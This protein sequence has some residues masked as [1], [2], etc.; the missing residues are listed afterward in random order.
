MEQTWT[1]SGSYADWTMTITAVTPEHLDHLDLK[2]FPDRA[3]RRLADQF[4]DAVSLYECRRDQ[5]T[6]CCA[7]FGLHAG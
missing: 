4:A 6:C 3:F 5:E 2:Q 1:V 7:R